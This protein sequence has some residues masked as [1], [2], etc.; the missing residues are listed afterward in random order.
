MPFHIL[1]LNW[2]RYQKKREINCVKMLL[3]LFS[4]FIFL[5]Q[6]NMQTDRS[7]VSKFCLT[8][9]VRQPQSNLFH[10][11]FILENMAQRIIR[12]P[13]AQKASNYKIFWTKIKEKFMPCIYHILI[14]SD[15]MIDL[16]WPPISMENKLILDSSK[17][18]AEETLNEKKKKA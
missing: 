12:L 16:S 6:L 13:M 11:I 9:W 17:P 1:E 2:N 7:T 18:K 5:S 3:L 10:D 8:L 4:D 15:K 14:N